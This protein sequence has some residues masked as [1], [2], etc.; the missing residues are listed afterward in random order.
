[1]NDINNTSR[2]YPRTLAEAFPKEPQ[3]AYSATGQR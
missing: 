3:N 2:K 1:M